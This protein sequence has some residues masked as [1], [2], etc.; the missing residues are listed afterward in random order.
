MTPSQTGNHWNPG[1]EQL[2]AYVDGELDTATFERLRSWL[3][4]HPETSAELR[5]HQR[6]IHLWQTAEPVQPSAPQWAGA[7]DRVEKGIAATP[8]TLSLW[9]QPF[10]QLTLLALGTAAALLLALPS[11]PWRQAKEPP[12]G[13]PA[14][15]VIVNETEMVRLR[16]AQNEKS[17]P[18]A[19]PGEDDWLEGLLP[20]DFQWTTENS[21]RARDSAK[22]EARNRR[23][24]TE[25][26]ASDRQNAPRA[27]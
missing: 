7:L 25:P 17:A 6:L 24:T 3:A 12:P 4:D 11:A 20:D 23:S 19:A 9:Q 18:K 21:G 26:S 13:Q 10:F 2:A 8:P 15:E 22:R 5:S 1:A 16:P 14:R 27:P